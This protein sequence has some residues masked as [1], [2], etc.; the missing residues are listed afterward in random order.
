VAG[1]DA[2]DALIAFARD[3]LPRADLRVGEMEQLPWDDD[4]FDLVTGF[5]SF[6]FANDMVAALREARRVAKPSGRVVAQVWG[7]HEN[8]D[9]EAMK[10]IVRPFLPPRPPDAPPDLDLSAPGALAQVVS[11]AGLVVEDEFVTSWTTGY[12]DRAELVRASLAVAGLAVLAGL[13][14]E[15]EL[16][17]A[18]ISGL[19]AFRGSDDSYR[20]TNE[21]RIVIARPG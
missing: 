8:C 20:F 19:A 9:L 2:S 14:R 4:T 16:E 21:Y 5:N 18:I 10:A 13:D 12:R 1:L 11:R 3:R 7:A 15:A 6:F 17:H